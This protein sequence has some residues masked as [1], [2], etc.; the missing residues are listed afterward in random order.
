MLLLMI[1][2]NVPIDCVIY[3][4]TGMEFP[5]MEAHIWTVTASCW[6]MGKNVSARRAFPT[7]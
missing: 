3:A 1:E 6:T 2:K 5:E 4:N 7:R